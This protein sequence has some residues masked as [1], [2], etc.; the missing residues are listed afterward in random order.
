MSPSDGVIQS[1]VHMGYVP[2]MLPRR[3]EDVTAER[4]IVPG[5]ANRMVLLFVNLIVL[6]VVSRAAQAIFTHGVAVFSNTVYA[7]T[8]GLSVVDYRHVNVSLAGT[9]LA[10]LALCMAPFVHGYG[11]GTDV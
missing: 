10:G 1:S 6:V 3:S 7:D 11:I 9:G 2:F 5:V 8:F 4:D